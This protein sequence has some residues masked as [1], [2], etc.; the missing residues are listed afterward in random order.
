VICMDAPILHLAD[1]FDLRPAMESDALTVAGWMS[2]PHVARWWQQ[3]WSADRWSDEIKRLSAGD[4]SVPCMVSLDGTELGYL[5]LYRVQRDPLSAYYDCDVNDWG[6]H[7][8]IGEP[9][10][11]GGGIGRRLLAAL[12]D[13]LFAAD[14]RCRRVVAEPDVRNEASIRAFA[15]AGFVAVAQ[16]QLP[17]K[18]AVLMVCPRRTKEAE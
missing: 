14:P 9:D 11:I 13:A 7:V 18:T 6:V 5:E 15:A 1:G 17:D 2:Q 10:R 16:V 12:T 4:C 8:A 3:P